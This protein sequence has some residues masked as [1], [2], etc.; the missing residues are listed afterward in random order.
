MYFELFN[1][2][3]QAID[4]LQKAQQNTENA[5]IESKDKPPIILEDTLKKE[6]S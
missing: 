3:S 2:V 1:G 4:I 5:F 6:D